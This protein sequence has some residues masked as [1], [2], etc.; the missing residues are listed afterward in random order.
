MLIFQAKFG[1]LCAYALAATL[2]AALSGAASPSRAGELTTFPKRIYKTCRGGAAKI[3]DECGDQLALY[4]AARRRA[5]REGKILLVSVG[6][7]WCIWCHVFSDYVKG[8][9]GAFTHT[10]SDQNDQERFTETIH[11][12]APRDVSR[13]AGDLAEFVA[14]H[15]VLAHIELQ[16]APKGRAAVAASGGD[17]HFQNWFPFVYTVRPDGR[18]AARLEHDEVESRRDDEKDWFRGYDRMKLKAALR[19]MRDAARG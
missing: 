9:H 12:R 4:R 8:V 6:A 18:F 16:Y 2:F 11:E 19:R 17:A 15:F 1:R 3:Y 7:E 13:E 14:A 10:F 5:H